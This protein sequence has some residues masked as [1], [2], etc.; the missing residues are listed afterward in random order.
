MPSGL[1]MDRLAECRDSCSS[2]SM[3]LLSNGVEEVILDI[4]VIITQVD[5][6][7][8]HLR[9]FLWVYHCLKSQRCNGMILIEPF[10]EG[11]RQRC[12]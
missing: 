4:C 8:L 9:D 1:E 5:V 11:R 2:W 6:G 10:S 7:L 3:R 12:N